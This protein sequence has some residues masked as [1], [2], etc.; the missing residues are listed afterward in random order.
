MAHIPVTITVLLRLC[1]ILYS[2]LFLSCCNCVTS[3]GTFS[4]K[5]KKNLIEK[6]NCKTNF[7]V[8][9]LIAS[10]VMK[11][12]SSLITPQHPYIGHYDICS[13]ALFISR[14]QKITQLNKLTWVI[15][16]KTALGE[17]IWRS[18]GWHRMRLLKGRGKQQ[19]GDK[20]EITKLICLF[21][22]SA[23]DQSWIND[24]QCHLC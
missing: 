11:R 19:K 14:T 5:K 8:V 6:L 21:H 9:N 12:R 18:R 13:K 3:R 15:T 10:E 23:Y 24:T 22:N 1:E 16:L 17:C 4:S 2:F 20:N 7:K